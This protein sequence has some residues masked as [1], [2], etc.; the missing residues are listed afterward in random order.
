MSATTRGS[1]KRDKLDRYY[2]PPKCATACVDLLP[3]LGSNK[4]H[5]VSDA[6]GE[7][8]THLLG[9]RILEPGVGGGAFARA[10]RLAGAHV[11]GIDIDPGAPGFDDCDSAVIG[12]FLT[13]DWHAVHHFDAVIGNPIFSH[14]E[15]FVR[16][17]LE[18]APCVGFLLRSAF[19]SGARRGRGLL[20]EHP[21][22]WVY[23]LSERPSFVASG[24]TDSADYSFIIWER[25][26]SGLFRGRVV[27]WK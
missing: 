2:S 27:S 18:V 1:T 5:T 3:R 20:S 8:R 4:A 7:G 6:L 15:D 10:L 26:W 22:R 21:P 24:A 13:H 17:G 19:L 25:G 16:R 12:D 14:A 11:T 23:P 9:A